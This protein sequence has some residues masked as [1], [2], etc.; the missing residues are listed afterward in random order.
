M[1]QFAIAI[2]A[3]VM[4]T[5]CVNTMTTAA[6]PAIPPLQPETIPN[7]PVTD[8]PLLWQPGHWNWNGAG[9]EWQ[10]GLYIPR[11]DHGGTYLP[12]HWELTNAGYTW[13]PFQW[14]GPNPAAV[15]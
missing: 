2:A 4:L 13:V 8:I 7:P 11:D 6:Y 15:R 5:G 1:K 14:L 10:P 9:Y 3:A 12:G